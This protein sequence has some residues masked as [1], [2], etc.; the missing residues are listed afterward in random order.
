[1]KFIDIAVAGMIG[2]S[3]IASLLVW[4]P[5]T[6]DIAAQRAAEQVRLRDGLMNV[7]DSYGLY[8]LQESPPRGICTA[9]GMMSNSA[10]TFSATVD[11]VPCSVPRGPLGVEANLTVRIGAR[12]VDLESWYTGRA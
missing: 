10:V 8:W 6:Y 2:I 4:T 11:G 12:L 3:S 1:V 9:L 7:V 5:S